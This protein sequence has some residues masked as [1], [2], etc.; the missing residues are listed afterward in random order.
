LRS[1]ELQMM[2]APLPAAA[3]ISRLPPFSS[4]LSRHTVVPNAPLGPC[5]TPFRWN[6][7]SSRRHL[8]GTIRRSAS[9]G[10][11]LH[12]LFRPVTPRR[13]SWLRSEVCRPMGRD[14]TISRCDRANRSQ[15]VAPGSDLGGGRQLSRDERAGRA[16]LKAARK[17]WKQTQ[18]E[19]VQI[20]FGRR[21]SAVECNLRRRSRSPV[22]DLRPRKPPS[23]PSVAPA[24]R[25]TS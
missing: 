7:C 1:L 13:R 12:P 22:G 24:D 8:A 14:D 9:A 23:A 21:H 16:P 2:I 19:E 15:C 5:R 10:A 20:A 25:V 18:V 4:R 6:G 11:Y 3:S 17:L